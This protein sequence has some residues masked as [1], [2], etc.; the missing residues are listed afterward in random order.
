M[1]MKNRRTM[2]AVLVWSAA[3]AHAQAFEVVSIREVPR[4]APILMRDPYET[5]ILAGGRFRD[6]R[7]TLASLI[8][9]AFDI[10]HSSQLTGVS[11]WAEDQAFSISANPADGFPPLSAAENRERVRAM[12]RDMLATRFQLKIHTET[13]QD[14][15]FTLQV[16]RGGL[17]IK[18]VDPPVPPEKEG[19]TFLAA[20]DSG[21]R[22][23]GDKT[24][25]ARFASALATIARQPVLDQTGLKNYYTFNVKWSAP[26]YADGRSESGFG[27]DGIN[28]MANAL[29]DLFGLQLKGEIVP[30]MHW[31]V[32]RAERPTPN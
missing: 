17:K 14:R 2:A 27:M 28:G 4:D 5:T 13:R 30:T 22:I 25:M 19:F 1:V 32:D 21:G 23:V 18:A 10:P 6:P 26:E 9:L 7:V 24:T 15:G 12:I 11:G 8:R 3:F 31:I 20:S 16:A 29:K